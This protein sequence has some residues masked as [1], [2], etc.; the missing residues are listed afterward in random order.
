[1]LAR[2]LVRQALNGLCGGVRVYTAEG[3]Q[4]LPAHKAKTSDPRLESI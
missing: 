4:L 3:K 2:E 1:M